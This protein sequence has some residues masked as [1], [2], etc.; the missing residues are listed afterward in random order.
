MNMTLIIAKLKFSRANG[1]TYNTVILKWFFQPLF[2]NI[3]YTAS[4]CQYA[5]NHFRT[6]FNDTVGCITT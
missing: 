6:I 3:R 4:Q 2:A 5:L 1:W